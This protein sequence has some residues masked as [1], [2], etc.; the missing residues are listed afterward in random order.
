MREGDLIVGRYRLDRKLGAGGMGEVWKATDTEL[1][2]TVAL[3]QALP[4]ADPEET[5][6]LRHEARIAATLH[7]PNIVTVFDVLVDGADRWLVMEYVEAASLAEKLR[8]EHTLPPRQVAYL[9]ARVASALEAVHA[10]GVVHGDVKPGNVLVT[11]S[12]EPKLTDFGVS[13]RIWGE[14]TLDDS[15]PVRGTPAYQ[16]PEVGEGRTPNAASDMFSLGAT[17]FAAVEGVPRYGPAD[18]A[19]TSLRRQALD[20][21]EPFRLSGPLMSVLETLL[22]RDPRV[23]PTAAAANR[24]LRA[25]ADS[26]VAPVDQTDPTPPGG[27]SWWQRKPSRRVAAVLA[28]AVLVVGVGV[29]ALVVVLTRQP[30]HAVS[31]STPA[32]NAS[33]RP[34]AAGAGGDS[35]MSSVMGDQRTADPCALT[36]P[37]LLQRFGDTKQDPAYGNFDRCDEIVQARPAPVDVETRF[38]NPNTPAPPPP[39]SVT[40]RG[41]VGVVSA[42][43]DQTHCDRMVLLSDGSTVDVDAH[44]KNDPG[45]ADLCAMADTEV[46]SAVNT[47]NARGVP[48]RTAPFD[49]KSLATVDACQLLTSADLSMINGIDASQSQTDFGDWGCG[50]SSTTSNTNVTVR[51][52]RNQPLDAQRGTPIQLGVR[53]AFMAGTIDDGPGTCMVHVVN[54]TYTD[55]AGDPISELAD[56]EVTGDGPE[57]QLCGLATTLAGH[58]AARLPT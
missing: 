7:H 19:L 50:W 13:R 43:H 9:G 2:R 11:G 4:G 46:T 27:P 57:N 8:D 49:P 10:K 36:E 31:G 3:K 48:R 32:A 53:S 35:T 34:A 33:H 15:G 54:R 47:I 38:V 52:N 45:A 58:V 20:Q 14:A 40:H 51:F 44:W 29:S 24:L 16:A 6:R 30:G 21:P 17:L 1:R 26:P 5:E 37:G 28:A 39:G 55:S 56:V 41:S 18:N 25:V 22:D 23:R 42:G 12:G